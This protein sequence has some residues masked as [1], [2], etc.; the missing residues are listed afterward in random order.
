MYLSS[1]RAIQ[2]DCFIQL[3]NQVSTKC[4]LKPSEA[5]DNDNG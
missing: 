2:G 3:A 1:F 5:S 4:F